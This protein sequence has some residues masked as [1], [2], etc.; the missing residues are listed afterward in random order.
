MCQDKIGVDPGLQA[1]E[2]VFHRAAFIWQIAVAK[3]E[4]LDSRIVNACQEL[5][6]AAPRLVNAI[7]VGREHDPVDMNV[8]PRT[9]E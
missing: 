9:H 2:D 6:R 4:D 1:L 3:R 5:L 8:G 7:A